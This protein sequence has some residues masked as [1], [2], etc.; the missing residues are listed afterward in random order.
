MKI[1]GL[2]MK[3]GGLGMKKGSLGMKKG[4]LGMK[5]VCL[6]MNKGGLGTKQALRA[7]GESMAREVDS[8][9]GWS[10]LG[11][12]WSLWSQSKVSI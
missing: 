12:D 8:G 5:K 3:K 11:V 7:S 1:G 4:S 2:W 9:P 6:G 10:W